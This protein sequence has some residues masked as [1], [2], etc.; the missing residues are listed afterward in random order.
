MEFNTE[1]SQKMRHSKYQE[2]LA[3]EDAQ[4]NSS[5]KEKTHT[6]YKI[7]VLIYSYKLN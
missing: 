2:Q 3:R 6:F 7:F 1:I 4:H 5:K